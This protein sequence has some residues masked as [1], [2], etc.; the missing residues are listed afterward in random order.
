[1]T[2]ERVLEKN[3]TDGPIENRFPVQE[4]PAREAWQGAHKAGRRG[5]K[6]KFRSGRGEESSTT[7]T[8]L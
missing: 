4:T 3:A 8:A 2:V 6:K 5:R 1:M 7:A